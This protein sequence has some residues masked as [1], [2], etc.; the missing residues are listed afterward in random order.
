MIFANAFW[1]LIGPQPWAHPNQCKPVS[2]YFLKL[3][4]CFK[5]PWFSFC[6]LHQR[7]ATLQ[8]RQM[9]HVSTDSAWGGQVKTPW[10]WSFRLNSPNSVIAPRSCITIPTCASAIKWIARCNTSALRFPWLSRLV[11][12]FVDLS[13]FFS[14][15]LIFSFSYFSVLFDFGPWNIFCRLKRIC[16][17]HFDVRINSHH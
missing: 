9:F 8:Q 14:L 3:D 4:P 11:T 2:T 1:F 10:A 16:F 7:R 17:G 5:F 13:G 6:L 15:L 12:F